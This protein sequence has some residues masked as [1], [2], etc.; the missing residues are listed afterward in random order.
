MNKLIAAL[1]A[2]LFAAGA[3][4]QTAPATAA[5]PASPATAAAPAKAEGKKS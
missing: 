2:G 5:T 3:I 4:A 1:M